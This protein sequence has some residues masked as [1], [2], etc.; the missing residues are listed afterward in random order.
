MSAPP[1]SLV[2]PPPRHGRDFPVL[3]TLRAVGALAVLTTHATFWSGDYLRHGVLG[4]LF[5]RLDVGVALFFVLS[6]FLLARPWLVA[7]MRAEP[8][9]APALGVYAQR[10]FLRIVPLYVVTVVV[11]LVFIDENAGLGAVDWLSTLL[12]LDTISGTL[13]PA[14]LTQMWS[15]AAEVMFY[16][17]LPALMALM[18]GRAPVWRAGRFWSVL[19]G[20]AALNVWWLVDGA[21][22]AGRLAT[23]GAPLQWLPSYLTWF[24]VGLLLAAAHALDSAGRGTRLTRALRRLAGQPGACW[25]VAGALLVVSATPLAGP[26]MFTAPD[27]GDLL[28]KNLLYAA[29]ALSVVLTGIWPT[30]GSTYARA[31]SARPLRHLG[32]ISYGIFCLHLP[33]LHLVMWTTGWELFEGHGPEIWLLALLGSVVAAEVAYRVVERPVLLWEERRRSAR[34]A[35]SSHPATTTTAS[36]GT[37]AR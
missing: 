22:R 26:T 31:A 2:A 21:A 27:T 24:G 9:P 12:M 34:V 1:P 4:T 37:S 7:A 6:G 8:G 28:V 17:G 30:E 19:L 10:R 23:D 29:V 15:L 32:W 33:V 13:F 36:S 16:L 3:D 5:A 14:G 35:R 20:L 25:T 11:A 18:L